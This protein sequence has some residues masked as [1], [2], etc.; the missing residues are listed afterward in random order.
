MLRGQRSYLVD[1]RWE[2]FCR[3]ELWTCAAGWSGSHVHVRF[4][5]NEDLLRSVN[6]WCL[7][8]DWVGQDSV[9]L[10]TAACCWASR[11]RCSPRSRRQSTCCSPLS[12]AW[13][14]VHGTISWRRTRW[15][16]PCD[17]DRG[18]R[19]LPNQSRRS[20]QSSRSNWAINDSAPSSIDP[21]KGNLPWDHS[22]CS[23]ANCSVS[24]HDVKRSPNECTWVRAVFGTESSRRAHY[25]SSVSSAACASPSPWDTAQC[26]HLSFD[27][28]LAIEWCLGYWLS[29]KES[30]R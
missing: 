18:R 10:G 22:W 2:I 26:R 12:W 24:S 21:S 25:W 15:E 16:S 13:S 17:R 7:K 19:F 5:C 9:C 4:V 1:L 30:I 28:Y 27:R 14:Q 29:L 11:P 20:K 23:E 3:M 8:C 6:Q